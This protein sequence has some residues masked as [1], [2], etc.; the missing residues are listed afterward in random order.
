MSSRPADVGFP[1]VLMTNR[2]IIAGEGR[3]AQDEHAASAQREVI[4][5]TQEYAVA[6]LDQCLMPARPCAHP[7]GSSPGALGMTKLLDQPYEAAR[8]TV[9]QQM[10]CSRLITSHP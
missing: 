7:A 9:Y 2:P 6:G 5:E 4:E 1:A 3:E 10:S 8:R